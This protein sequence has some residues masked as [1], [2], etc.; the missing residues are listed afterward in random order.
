MKCQRCGNNEATYHY[1]TNVN[2]KITEAHLCQDCAAQLGENENVFGQVD[3]M[4]EDMIGSFFGR[5]SGFMPSWSMRPMSFAMPAMVMPY[6]Q[7]GID[8]GTGMN[9]QG[10]AHGAAKTEQSKENSNIDP[11][12]SRRREINALREQ[13]KQAVDEENFE[14]AAELRDKIKKIEG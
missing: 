9:A 12:L 2:G 7:I 3:K 14:K 4:F 13:M 1:K 5:S 8:D 6:I 10:G 11:E